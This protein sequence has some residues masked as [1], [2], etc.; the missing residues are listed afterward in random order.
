MSIY[1]RVRTLLQLLV[2]GL[3]QLIQRFRRF[4]Q[5]SP[6]EQWQVAGAKVRH[7]LLD[8][9]WEPQLGNDKTI[10]VVGLFGSGRWYVNNLIVANV[11]VRAKYFLDELRFHVRPTS[12]IY[13]GHATIKYPAAGLPPAGA[14]ILEAVRSGLADLIFVYRH[15]LDCL[16]TNWVWWRNLFR[17]ERYDSAI[18]GDY[19]NTDEFCADL[20]E[21]FSEFKAF[22]E[23]DPLFFWVVSGPRFLTFPEF[24]EETELYIQSATLALRLEDFTI[25]ASKEFSKIAELMFLDI[26]PRSLRLVPPRA[27]PFRHL[28]VRNK[29]PPFRDFIQ[30]LDEQTKKRVNKIYGDMTSLP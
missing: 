23:G 19:K 9:G 27:E 12:M 25:D 30:R 6:S 10:Y 24:V 7:K 26:D 3:V 11:G 1:L 21:N 13:S 8:W 18:S 4:T 20:L 28:V 22:A 29:V 5:K 2:R 15:P 16:L 17:L 14:R